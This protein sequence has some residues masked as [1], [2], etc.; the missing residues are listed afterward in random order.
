M[1]GV[2]QRISRNVI[3]APAP[4]GEAGESES[5][6]GGGCLGLGTWGPMGSEPNGYGVSSGDDGN[7]L[8]ST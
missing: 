8:N 7:F 5:G 3:H 4:L 2:F 6:V 1:W